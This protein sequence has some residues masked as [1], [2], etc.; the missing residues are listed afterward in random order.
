VAKKFP[1]MKAD[2]IARGLLTADLRLTDAG[3]AYVA[4]LIMQI[5]TGTLPV[6]KKRKRVK[7][8]RRAGPRPSKNVDRQQVPLDTEAPGAMFI[9]QS[10]GHIQEGVS[11]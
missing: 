8:E 9:S 10:T 2:L 7:W 11:L 1:K 6:A 4:N 5:K 3:N